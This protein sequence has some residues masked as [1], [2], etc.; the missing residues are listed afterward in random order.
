MTS[1]PKMA[2]SQPRIV[3]RNLTANSRRTTALINS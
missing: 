2:Q 1:G 3:P